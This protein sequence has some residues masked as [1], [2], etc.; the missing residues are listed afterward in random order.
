MTRLRS[1]ARKYHLK[2]GFIKSLSWSHIIKVASNISKFLFESK[3]KL[4]KGNVCVKTKSVLFNKLQS[5]LLKVLRKAYL[6]LM[7]NG[8]WRKKWVV[9]S[10]LWPQLQKG[11]EI[12][13]KLCLNLCSLKWLSRVETKSRNKFNSFRI[14]TV[15]HRTG[16]WSYKLK[17]IFLICKKTFRITKPRI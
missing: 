12:S 15:I 1:V 17:N 13:W 6:S 11:F 2:Q 9:D 10:I 3:D 4:P 7:N 5:I 8:Q 14:M 16:S